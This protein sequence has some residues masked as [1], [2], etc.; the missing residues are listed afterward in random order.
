MAV[1]GGM[2]AAAGHAPKAVTRRL[3]W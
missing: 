3:V 2:F 1:L